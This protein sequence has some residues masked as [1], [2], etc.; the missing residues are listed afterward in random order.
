MSAGI[1][2]TSD[3][4]TPPFVS[5]API[6]INLHQ[7][8]RRE[9]IAASREM[10]RMDVYIIV[11]RHEYQRLSVSLSLSLSPKVLFSSFTR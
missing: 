6:S 3:W 11:I 9:L 1:A 4:Q 7:L 2:E 5:A 10:T 8:R